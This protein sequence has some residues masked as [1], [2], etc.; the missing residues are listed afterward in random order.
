MQEHREECP[1]SV[2]DIDSDYLLIQPLEIA[3]RACRICRDEWELWSEILGKT[4]DPQTGE[5]TP[6]FGD[7]AFRALK[8]WA[9]VSEMGFPVTGLSASDFDLVEAA[10][11]AVNTR[12]AFHNWKLIKDSNADAE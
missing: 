12:K 6:M 5:R 3:K 7:L 11:A 4:A 1:E 9:R 2:W 8:L 10:R